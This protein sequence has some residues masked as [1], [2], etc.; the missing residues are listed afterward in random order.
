MSNSYRIRTTP[1][2]NKNISVAID[3]DFEYLEILSLKIVQEDL[4]IRSCSDYGVVIGRISVNNGFGLPNIKVSIFIPL[5][6]EDSTN[7]IISDIYP[8]KTISD[9]NEDG[10]RYN[11][12]PYIQSHSN[13]T[14]TGTFFTRKDVLVDSTLIEVYDKYYK[15]TTTTNDSGDFMLFGVP[16][17]Q[18]TLFVDCDLSDIGEFSL[19]PNDLIRM[20]I[21][22]DDMVDKN[23]FKSSNNLKSLPQIVSFSRNI[24]VAALWG[25][26]ELCNLGI[27]RTDFDLSD[28][29]NVEIKPNAV[30]MGSLI[31][32]IDDTPIDYECYPDKRIGELCVLSTGPGEIKAIRQTIEFDGKGRPSLEVF[33]LQNAGQ[34]IDTDG[35]WLV[36]IPMNLDYVITNEFGEQVI[37][38]DPTQG[39]PTKGKYRFKVKWNQPPDLRDPIKRGYYLVP[40]IREYGWDGSGNSFNVTSPA[41][42]LRS[43]AFSTNWDDYGDDT[44]P[45][46]QLMIQ[47][48]I[49]CEDKF[50]EFKYNKVYTVSNLITGYKKGF[51][52]RRFMGIKNILDEQCESENNKFPANDAQ[53]RTDIIFLLF[54]ILMVLMYPVMYYIMILMHIISFIV[55]VVLQPLLVL[56]A[57]QM[58]VA[59]GVET[60]GVFAAFVFP[61]APGLAAIHAAKAVGYTALVVGLTILI[62]KIQKIKKYFQNFKI[63]NFTYPDCELCNCDAPSASN[64]EY[65]AAQEAGTG[66]QSN[67][68]PVNQNGTG[69]LTPFTSPG[70]FTVN[71]ES[72]LFGQVF[73]GAEIPLEGGIGDGVGTSC[74]CNYARVEDTNGDQLPGYAKII[75]NS[76]DEMETQAYRFMSTDLPLPERI[77]LFNVKAKYFTKT[78]PN[79]SFNSN[80][81]AENGGKG[82]N[83]M[84]VRFAKDL[85]SPSIP[86]SNLPLGTSCHL[87][88]VLVVVMNSEIA[89]ELTTGKIV[90]FQNLQITKDLNFTSFPEND[91]GTKSITGTSVLNP[92]T[93][94]SVNVTWAKP[95]GV[96]QG[97]NNTTQ[98]YLTGTSLNNKMFQ[99]FPF[100]IEYFQIITA[101]TITNFTSKM[102]NDLDNSFYRRYMNSNFYINKIRRYPMNC[103]HR[104]EET[105]WPW[106]LGGLY[107]EKF[108]EQV[109]VIL[110]RGVDPHSTRTKCEFDLSK[111]FG[112]NTFGKV[113]VDGEN[114]KYKY[115]L[116]IP[117]QGGPLNIRHRGFYNDGTDTYSGQKLFHKSFQFRPTPSLFKPFKTDLTT[118]YSAV[119]NGTWYNNGSIGMGQDSSFG[120]K[121][122][123]SINNNYLVRWTN[124]RSAN[125]L[126]YKPRQG[127]YD[128]SA[129]KGYNYYASEN[130]EGGSFLSMYNIIFEDGW[131]FG[132]YCPSCK[133]SESLS[134]AST[135]YYSPKDSTKMEFVDSEHIVMRGDRLPFSAFEYQPNPGENSYRPLHA[136]PGFEVVLLDDSGFDSGANVDPGVGDK[137]NELSGIQATLECSNLTPFECYTKKPDGTVDTLP[138]TDSCWQNGVNGEIIM[139]KGC[140]VVVTVPLLSIVKDFLL[141]TEWRVR[142][143]TNFAACRNVFGHIFKNNWINGTLFAYPFQNEVTFDING[144]ATSSYC[145]NVIYFDTTTNNFYYK[146]TPYYLPPNATTGQ[147]IGDSRP[148]KGG[149]GGP[150]RNLMNP[151]TIMDL[152]PRDLFIQEVSVTDDYDGYIVNKLK[153]TTYN[154]VSALLNVFLL[155]RLLSNSLLK[156]LTTAGVNRFFDERDESMI[157]GDY[158]QMVSINSEYGVVPFKPN[159]YT[160]AN[161]IFQS[162]GDDDSIFGIFYKSV[163]QDRDFISPKRTILTGKGPLSTINCAFDDIP[164]KTQTVPFYLW[165]IKI[166]K[167]GDNIFGSQTN[168]WSTALTDNNYLFSHKYQ[169]LDR[170]N[171]NSKYFRTDNQSRTDSFKGYIYSVS[172]SLDINGNPIPTA[173]INTWK[174]SMPNLRSVNTGAPFFFY[175][176]LKKGSS[177]FDKFGR[178]WLDFDNIV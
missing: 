97:S 80:I 139:S 55:I 59:A 132:V 23:K 109:V 1:G 26:P 14:P 158:A 127:S 164:F 135:L 70:M 57:I 72:S 81:S 170:V 60:A 7:P 71:G 93:P 153:S 69:L 20:G 49:N 84:K 124:R 157:D 119:D 61:G 95:D 175:F 68:R 31:S 114:G 150:D 51:S 160:D 107:F 126:N 42:V 63:A 171:S 2:I 35:V 22:T 152:G 16:T 178:V 112:Y 15:F 130:I 154:D 91:Y 161:L 123:G 149:N 32:T 147:F 151:T 148:S 53:K 173:D 113:I 106:S 101:M 86:L 89:K 141:L 79:S 108:N 142:L 29:V 3:Q 146:S 159:S 110:S 111:I 125:C 165:D 19:T 30:F 75:T 104:D 134:V 44:T 13:H 83:Q 94:S 21:A 167:D 145:K 118:M 50:Y 138:T 28:E 25:E 120:A 74:L 85:N 62:V 105:F 18:Q 67:K 82:T 41:D 88:N 87:D 144:E 45:L 96:G 43:Y 77:N 64:V 34:V 166:N 121:V 9:V 99:G 172:T 33:N 54:T 52:R 176:G 65:V 140:Y 102:S 6:D 143:T 48:A 115:K 38:S 156:N 155:N 174:Q 39:I 117:I 40:N 162:S 56:F 177:A 37:S 58:A 46:G 66:G 169:L 47:D 24:E 100:D 11:L 78:I 4:Y 90:A 76:D 131:D 168:E 163:L 92:T 98:Y 36:D 133:T 8:Y 10:Y 73:S 137:D 12:L 136:N 129:N 17:G 116:N 27:T 5:S 128:S 103:N 122:G